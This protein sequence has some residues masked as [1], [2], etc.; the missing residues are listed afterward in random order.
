VPTCAK[1]A[2]SLVKKPDEF[3]PPKTRD[4]LYGIIM[5]KKKGKLGKLKL[6]GKIT[7]DSIRA[8]RTTKSAPPKP[9]S[10]TGVGPREVIEFRRKQF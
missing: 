6:M 9:G 2:I 5:A 8:G 4:D 7:I 3:I 10:Q 1:E